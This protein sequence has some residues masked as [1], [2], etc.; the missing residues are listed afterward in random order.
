MQ[1]PAHPTHLQW[2]TPMQPPAHPGGLVS[3]RSDRPNSSKT[4]IL[5]ARKGDGLGG[6]L[7]GGGFNGGGFGGELGRGIQFLLMVSWIH[8]VYLQ[9]LT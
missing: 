4:P 7:M 1:P 9:R 6:G 2:G 8:W 3:Q 5:G